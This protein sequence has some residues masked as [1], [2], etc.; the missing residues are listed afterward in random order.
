MPLPTAEEL[1]A[2]YYDMT[3]FARKADEMRDMVKVSTGEVAVAYQTLL[4]DY[5]FKLRNKINKM[6]LYTCD[7]TTEL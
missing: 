1:T 7:S 6:W 5:E 2:L 3:M 4:L